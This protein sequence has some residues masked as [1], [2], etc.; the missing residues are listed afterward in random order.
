MTKIFNFSVFPVITHMKA[1]VIFTWG[2][3]E[4]GLSSVND[5]PD[6]QSQDGSHGDQSHSCIQSRTQPEHHWFSLVNFESSASHWALNNQGWLWE[7][8]TETWLVI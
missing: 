5:E 7:G 4:S 3:V 8:Q 2:A 6:S 1:K